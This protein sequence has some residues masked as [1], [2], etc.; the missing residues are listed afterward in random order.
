MEFEFTNA[1]MP[2][3]R[4]RQSEV[5]EL[6]DQLRVNQALHLRRSRKAVEMYCY[7]Y[8]KMRGPQH[9]FICRD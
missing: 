2:E 8:R 7:R 5:T 9:R 4:K 1:P 3:R 6:L